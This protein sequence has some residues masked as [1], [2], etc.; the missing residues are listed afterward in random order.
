[1]SGLR[2]AEMDSAEM[3]DVVHVIFEEDYTNATSGEQ[4][5]AKNNVRKII[6]REFYEREYNYDSSSKT[7]YSDLEAEES[8]YDYSDVV[9]F[10]PAKAE[11]KPFVP[12]TDFDPNSELPFGKTLDAPLG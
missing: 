2:L 3:L 1:M 10:D 6:Y 4:V 8:G 11:R 9:P 5:D 7:E 12:S